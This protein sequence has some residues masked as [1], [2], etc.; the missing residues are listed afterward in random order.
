[1][2]WKPFPIRALGCSNDKRGY[3]ASPRGWS[4]AAVAAFNRMRGKPIHEN[5]STTFVDL[6]ALVRHLKNLQFVG[7][8]RLEFASY[9]AE[10]YFTAAGR[11]QAR[12][13]DR[14]EGRFAQGERAFRRILDRAREPM[15]RINVLRSEPEETAAQLRRAFV[16]DRI[17][18]QAR[19]AAFGTADT[20]VLNTA[21]ITIGTGLRAPSRED[22]ALAMDL[23]LTI[24]DPFDR[25]KMDFDTAF[26]A[27]CRAVAESYSFLDPGNGLFAFG[28]E[29]VAVSPRVSTAELFEGISAALAHMIA[30]LRG[31]AKFGKL[32]LYTR[33]RLQQHLSA[34]HSEYSKFG[35]VEKVDR[36][37]A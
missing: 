14:L 19:E 30:R 4:Q 32:L 25:A 7:T 31:D 10:I 3:S 28:V 17:V 22:A 15:G 35:V 12:E 1:M 16:D 20:I 9:E 33:H 18:S 23:I 13:Y 21:G 24:K 6:S 34:R 37:L 8:I 26:N 36:I 27:A 2:Q 29:F 5:L 11:L